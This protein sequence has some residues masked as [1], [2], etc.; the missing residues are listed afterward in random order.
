MNSIEP[1][2]CSFHRMSGGRLHKLCG[3]LGRLCRGEIEAGGG[4]WADLSKII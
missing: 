4:A 3:G 1:V 2:P